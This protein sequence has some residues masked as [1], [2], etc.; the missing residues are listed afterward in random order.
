M[1]D[2]GSVSQIE[3][4]PDGVAALTDPDLISRFYRDVRSVA[5][6]TREEEESLTQAISKRRA[7]L[8][9]LL[10]RHPRLVRRALEPLGKGAIDPSEGFREQEAVRILESAKAESR[11]PLRGR[12][13]RAFITR[14]EKELNAYRVLRDQMLAS[15]LR[16]VISLARR[17]NHPTLS[18]LDLVQEG[19]LGLLRA[20]ERFEPQRGIRFGTYALWWI[21]H[22]LARAADN[23]GPMIRTPVHWNQFRRKVRRNSRDSDSWPTEDELQQYAIESGVPPEYARAM[24]Q[25]VPCTSLDAPIDDDDSVLAHV[26]AVDVDTDPALLN[27]SRDISEHM[28][29][30]LSDLPPRECEILSLRF[31]MSDDHSLTLEEIG[32]RY[33]VSRERIRQIEARAIDKM[34]VICRSRGL[35]TLLE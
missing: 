14:F 7:R 22:H 33:G 17:Y 4:R 5:L 13:L 28:R 15:N 16:L 1:E 6:L 23:L 27:E 19:T 32:Q 29:A 2:T 20:I 34:R 26:A 11:N 9:T 31:G 12:S 24:E 3:P 8:C 18:Q 35:E 10:R 30:A 25:G 21:W